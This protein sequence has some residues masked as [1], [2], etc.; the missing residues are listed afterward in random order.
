MV[1]IKC[2]DG[3]SSQYTYRQQNNIGIA[4]CYKD[5]EETSCVET[6]IVVQTGFGD[7]SYNDAGRVMDRR[8]VRRE[9][10]PVNKKDEQ[11]YGRVQ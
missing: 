1:E 11:Q 10:R 7:E 9:I 8:D 3:C 2:G 4:K 6:R 5:N